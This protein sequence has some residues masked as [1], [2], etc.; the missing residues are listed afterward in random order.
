[1]NGV[2]RIGYTTQSRHTQYH[3]SIPRRIQVGKILFL[4]L[5]INKFFLTQAI[6]LSKLKCPQRQ[7]K[8]L[9]KQSFKP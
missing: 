7:R 4:L 9:V 6:Y 1:M 8:V 2:N 5:L 3:R